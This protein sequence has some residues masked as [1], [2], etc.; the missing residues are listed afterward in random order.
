ML[1]LCL[2]VN[3]HFFLRTNMADLIE[4]THEKHYELYR[5]NKLAD[6]GFADTDSESQPLR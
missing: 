2:F 3:G 4:K 1:T 5:K 6:M